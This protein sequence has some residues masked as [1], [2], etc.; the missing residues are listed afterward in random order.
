MRS[1]SGGGR[2][3]R[4][5]PTLSFFAKGSEIPLAR[6][7]YL[8]PQGG[9]YYSA[10]GSARSLSRFFSIMATRRMETS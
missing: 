7:R 10:S 8:P 1:I 3:Q 4:L 6:W 2:F 9:G 5:P